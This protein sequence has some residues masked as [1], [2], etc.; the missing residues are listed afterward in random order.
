MSDRHL[1][2]KETEISEDAANRIGILLDSID[3]IMAREREEAQTKAERE[4]RPIVAMPG[5]PHDLRWRVLVLGCSVEDMN[6]WVRHDPETPADQEWYVAT[7]IET[8]CDVYGVSARDALDRYF[9]QG[10]WSG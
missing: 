2:L 10:P 8:G 4:D 9:S 6:F 3:R 1:L 5:L 7:E